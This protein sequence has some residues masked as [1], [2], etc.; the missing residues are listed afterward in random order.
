VSLEELKQLAAE[1]QV[2]R[3]DM[4]WTAKLGQWS[5]AGTIH[6]LCPE[7]PPA[8]PPLP[9]VAAVPPPPPR[10]G[11]ARVRFIVPP[12]GDAVRDVVHTAAKAYLKI[13]SYGLLGGKLLGAES[14]KFYVHTR[15]IGEGPL[16]D[17]FDFRTE[18]PPGAFKLEVAHWKGTQEIDRKA[19]DLTCA[20]PGDYEIR[21]NYVKGTFGGMSGSTIEVLKDPDFPGAAADR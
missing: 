13:A 9:A 15:L 2:G 5:E 12:S 7:L 11:H 17:G 1:G 20:K 21:F 8:P 10:T 14:F 3:K 6:G 19:F 18:L 4:V 16:K